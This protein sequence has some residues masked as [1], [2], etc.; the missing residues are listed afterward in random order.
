MLSPMS[1]SIAVAL[2]VQLLLMIGVPIA[3]A[4]LVCRRRHIPLTV[5]LVAGGFFLL[6][7][8]V[9]APLTKL[10]LPLNLGAGSWLTLVLSC[11]VYGVCEELARY[12]SFRRITV[13]QEHRSDWGG[14][15]AGL[16]HGGTQSIA[17]GL[18]FAWGMFSILRFP[19]QFDQTVLD[20]TLQASP[21]LFLLTGI[22]RLPAIVFSVAFSL[23]V[24]AAFRYD[25]RFLPISIGLHSVVLFIVLA[26]QRLLPGFLYVAVAIALAIV[27]VIFVRRVVRSR[28]LADPTPTT[29]PAPPPAT[30]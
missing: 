18:Q 7:L 12:L 4:V 26:A 10:L 29:D 20:E 3:A 6:S 22:D 5:P 13:M 23:F 30:V 28:I 21:W 8:L 24:V 25:G 17:L 15:A 2:A 27:A 19:G 1:P 11:L 16:G 9:T 14:I